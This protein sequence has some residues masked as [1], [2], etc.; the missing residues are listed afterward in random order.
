M[1]DAKNN[2]CPKC[3][4]AYD[5]NIDECPR[6]GIV[7][8]KWEI[9]LSKISVNTDKT[10]LNRIDIDKETLKQ[11]ENAIR[12]R[13][14]NLADLPSEFANTVVNI[15]YQYHLLYGN[16]FPDY[17]SFTSLKECPVNK[18]PFEFIV[19]KTTAYKNIPILFDAINETI[20]KLREENIQGLSPRQFQNA[21]GILLDMVKYGIQDADKKPKIVRMIER[22]LRKKHV[23]EIPN[24]IDMIAVRS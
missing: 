2:K 1:E 11:C 24:L 22:R 17:L 21:I 19:E 6:C 7:F 16:G 8:K 3:G 4:F 10:N 12:E 15:Y 18:N 20:D 14:G 5:G 23:N 9:Y 13:L